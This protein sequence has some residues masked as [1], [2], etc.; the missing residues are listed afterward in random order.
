MKN[1][2]ID[3]LGYQSTNQLYAGSRTVV[4]QAI[5]EA[6]RSPVVIK[7]MR[8]EYPTFGE[9]VRFRNQYVIA[10][11]LDF[12]GIVKPLAL[13][14]YGQGYALVMEDVGGVSLANYLKEQAIALTHR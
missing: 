1:V 2:N 5:R 6:D 7:L 11:N 13:L 4:Y 10:Q 12:G 9:L 3:L 14:R 8:E